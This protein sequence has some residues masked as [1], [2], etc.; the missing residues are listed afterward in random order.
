MNTLTIKKFTRIH[1][2]ILHICFQPVEQRQHQ[3]R[4]ISLKIMGN[5]NRKITIG[6]IITRPRRSHSS[7]PNTLKIRRINTRRTNYIITC[8]IKKFSTRAG[9]EPP[10]FNNSSED[11][12]RSSSDASKSIETRS[13]NS[14]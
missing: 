13:N 14:L 8:R 5:D 9:L 1:F 4:G 7:P 11:F 3:L 2:K 12:I 6:R 10:N